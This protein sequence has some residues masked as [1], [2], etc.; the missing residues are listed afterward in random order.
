MIRVKAG[1]WAA[2]LF[3]LLPL[4]AAAQV[5]DVAWRPGPPSAPETPRLP[6][7]FRPGDPMPELTSGPV[8]FRPPLMIEDSTEERE[9]RL[10]ELS[11][12]G[13]LTEIRGRSALDVVAGLPNGVIDWV[14]AGL[15]PSPDCTE[16]LSLRSPEDGSLLDRIFSGSIKDASSRP[17]DDLVNQLVAREQKYFARFQDS[18][19]ATLGVENGSEDIDTDE[20][21]EDQRKIMFDA[22]RKLYFGRLGNRVDDRIRD[23]AFQVG[24][25]HTVDFAVAPALIAGYLYVRGWEKKVDL[26]GLKC[27]F[28]IEPLRRILERFEGSHN[29]LVS[30]A[31]LEVG[32]G[33]FPVKFIVSVGIQDGDALMDFVGIGT[34]VGKAKQVV[35]QEMEETKE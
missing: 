35:S 24:R 2:A 6:V 19:L 3:L 25:W 7:Y 26:F 8:P 27:G 20:L 17:F 23:E 4:S 9:R 14:A 22:A 18:D 30:A 11:K 34:S 13:L 5:V 10:F 28:Q 33:S 15:Q 29:D 21:M 12:C 1:G 16:E 31:S 32:V